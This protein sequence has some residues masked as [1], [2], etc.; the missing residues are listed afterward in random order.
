MSLRA[1]HIL[2]IAVS[3]LLAAGTGAWGVQAFVAEGSRGGLVYGVLSL[4]MV[5]V[6]V[7]YG[8]RV[9]RKLW[10]IAP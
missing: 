7:V 6:L 3:T 4:L 2:F 5:P 9:R 1:F 8:V 10:E